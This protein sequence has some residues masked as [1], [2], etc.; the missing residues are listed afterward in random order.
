MRLARHLLSKEELPK[1][2]EYLRTLPGKT[3]RGQAK[4]RQL[5]SRTRPPRYRYSARTDTG[6]IALRAFWG[7]HVEAMNFSGMGMRCMP[8]LGLSPHAL[9][10]WRDRLEESADEMDWRSELHPSARAQ[11]SNADN[12]ARRKYCLTSEAPGRA[13]EPAP[14]RR[15]TKPEMVQES[16]KLRVNFTAAKASPPAC[17]SAGASSPA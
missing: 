2:A 16:E 17:S 8:Q 5:K 3:P 9:R 7:M 15:P 14:P 12:C 6:S 10:I 11:L 13:V 1:R 4:K